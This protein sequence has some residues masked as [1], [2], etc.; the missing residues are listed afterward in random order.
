GLLNVDT[1][2]TGSAAIVSRYGN[3]GLVGARSCSCRTKA[4]LSPCAAQHSATHRLLRPLRAWQVSPS[5]NNR[6]HA[7]DGLREH[8]MPKFRIL[9]PAGASFTTAGGGYGYEMEALEGMDAE[10]VECP[11]TEE[12]FIA[13][14]KGA[15]AV[16]ATGLQFC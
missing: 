7:R 16:D 6:R 12:G 8:A 3:D 4:C 10:I 13:A 9:T 11:T 2:S 5:H 15:D 1:H 14:A